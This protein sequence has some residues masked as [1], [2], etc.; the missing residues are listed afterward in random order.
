M[1]MMMLILLMLLMVML[2]MIILMVIMQNTMVMMLRSMPFSR[3]WLEAHQTFLG[4]DTQH[5]L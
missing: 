4:K 3:Y 2:I 5:I 1:I